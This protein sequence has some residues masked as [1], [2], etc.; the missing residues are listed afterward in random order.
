[1]SNNVSTARQPTKIP[2]DTREKLVRRAKMRALHELKRK[3]PDEY[4]RIFNRIREELGVEPV[5]YVRPGRA[6]VNKR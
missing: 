3:H 6:P 1:M 2:R 4:G 5:G